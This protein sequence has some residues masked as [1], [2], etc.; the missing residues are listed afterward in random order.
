MQQSFCSV[1]RDLFFRY[2]GRWLQDEEHTHER[3]Q[4][5]HD[6]ITDSIAYAGKIQRA[7]V[8]SALLYDELFDDS[9]II[10][11]PKD[12]V[13]GDFHWVHRLKLPTPVTSLQPIARATACPGP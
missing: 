2:V 4:E 5:R 6:H 1:W 9:F 11:R 10:D 7:L 8:P 13:S 3:L 12:V